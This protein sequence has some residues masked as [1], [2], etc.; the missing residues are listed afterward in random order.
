M[1]YFNTKRAYKSRNGL[2]AE[3]FRNQ[4]A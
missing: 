4:A 2:T 1:V 3:K